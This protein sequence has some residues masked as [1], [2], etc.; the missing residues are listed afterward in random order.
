MPLTIALSQSPI[1]AVAS[2]RILAFNRCEITL[3]TPGQPGTQ[4]RG[5]GGL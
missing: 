2:S 3:D 5:S 1:A 4:G